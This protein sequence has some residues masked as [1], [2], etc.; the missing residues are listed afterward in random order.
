MTL[1]CARRTRAAL[2]IGACALGGWLTMAAGQT[3]VAPAATAAAAT[4]ADLAVAYLAFER[5]LL[6]AA[7][8]AADTARVNK[9][10]DALSLLFFSRNYTGA[11]QQLDALTASIQPPRGAPGPAG[12]TAYRIRLTPPV[13]VAGT[14]APAVSVLRLYEAGASS[15]P[16]SATLRLQAAG[17]SAPIDLPITMAPADGAPPVPAASLAAALRRLKPGRYE[18]GLM[19]GTT[20]L[21]SGSWAVVARPLGPRA[22]ANAAALGTLAAATPALA[23]ALAS[24]RARNALLADVPDPGNT[25]QMLVDPESLARQVEG[26][27]AALRQGRDPF[28]N[29]AGDYWRVLKLD[30]R[31]VPMRVYRPAGTPAAGGWPLVIALHGAGGDENMFMDAYGGGLIK[32]LADRHGVLVASPQTGALSGPSGPEAFDRL[33]DAMAFDYPVDRA[34]VFVVG[35]SAGG[36]AASALIVARPDRIAAAACLNG[37]SGIRG[38][39]TSIPPTLVTAGEF[40]PLI[41]PARIQPAAERAKAAG[42]PV[43]YRFIP[44]YGHTLAVT[45][46]LPEAMQWMLEK[47]AI[48]AGK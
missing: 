25:A 12:L 18:V 32:Q 34:R 42:L 16:A 27:I 3:P 6:A 45:K 41:P 4:R 47:A 26:E 23:Q 15:T 8:D 13:Y 30:A 39:V 7:L 48:G 33:V 36:M 9:A 31:D 46:I 22:E 24:T 17:A 19:D 44:N 40:D 43:E 21:S 20:F 29:R 11:I 5:A 2:L 10:F 38:G 35:H 28:A 1:A 37:F 14:T